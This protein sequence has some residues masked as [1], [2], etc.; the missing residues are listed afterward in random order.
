VSLVSVEQTVQELAELID[1]S[2]VDDGR[3]DPV[4]QRSAREVAE[5]AHRSRAGLLAVAG[6]PAADPAI[7]LA[8]LVATNRPLMQEDAADLRDYVGEGNGSEFREVIQSRSP[9]GH[10]V[11][12]VER[13]FDPARLRTTAPVECQLQA[14]VADVTRPRVAVFTLSSTTGRGWL[15][16]S[17]MFGRL[18][19]SVDFAD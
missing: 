6:H 1:K 12:I 7:L 19:A 13:T 9:R 10:P 17:R 3:P 15:E 5:I 2:R 8:V 4:S 14:V 11:V 18:I 16:L